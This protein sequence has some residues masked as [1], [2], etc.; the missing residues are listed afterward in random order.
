MLLT[1]ESKHQLDDRNRL[2]LPKGPREAADPVG[3]LTHG[4][5]GA[6]FLFPWDEWLAFSET[7]G[8]IPMYDLKGQET[9]AFFTSGTRVGADAQG[10]IVIPTELKEWAGIDRD[11]MLVGMRSHVA[12]WAKERWE[13]YRG[14]RFAPERSSALAANLSV[15]GAAQGE[16]EHD[17]GVGTRG[18][19]S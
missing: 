15:L 7:L 1:G 18:G 3:F 19:S 8:K 4:W 6:L 10:R 2:A 9:V 17:G 12:M 13:A 16:P 14:E 5:H 11:V